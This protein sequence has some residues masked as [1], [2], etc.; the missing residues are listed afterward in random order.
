MQSGSK[1]ITVAMMLRATRVQFLV[2]LIVCCSHVAVCSFDTN[3]TDMQALLEFKKTISDPRQSLM[4]WN[5]STNWCGWD[6][7]RCGVK[8]PN[9]VTSLN[10]TSKGLV[11]RISPS[12]GNM[13]FLN[14][15]VLVANSFTG[16][17]PLALG[18][19]RRLRFV[20]LSNNTLQGQIPSFGN[21]S[22]LEVLWLENN[23][24]VGVIPSDLP[25]GLQSLSF[26]DNSVGGTIPAS[27]ANI[28][29]LRQLDLVGNNIEGNIPTEFTRLLELQILYVG[30][31]KLSGPFPQLVLNLSKLIGFN[32]VLSGLSGDV[33]SNFGNS[34]PNLEYME[35]GGNFFHGLIPSGLSN[36]SKLF[37]IGL[38]Q[39]NFS[40]VVP[41]LGKLSRLSYLNLEKNKLRA[42]SRQDWE[43]MNSLANCTELQ[44]LSIGGN[45]MEGKVPNSLANL[46]SLQ[47]LIMTE[48]QLSGDFPSGVAYLNNLI[49]LSLDGNQFTG[50][51]P[52]WLGT[53]PNLQMIELER[54]IFT[55][56]I[57][58]SFSNMSRLE[59]MY[60]DSNQF[61]GHIPPIL[62][63]MQMLEVLNI[64]DN[65]LQGSI[66]KELFKM[67]RLMQINLSVNNLDGPL[68]S[69][70][71]NAKHLMYLQL[72]SNKLSGEIPS[73][74]ENCDS[75][76]DIELDRN[77]FNGSI[78]TSL[79]NI[80]GLLNINLSHNELTGPIPLSLSS[81]QLL[82][83]LDL[84]FNHLEGEVPT[85]GIFSNV[86]AMRIDGNPGLCGGE[87]ELHLHAC[88]AMT[89][90]SRKHKHSTFEKLMIPLATI[91]PLA[92][93]VYVVLVWKRKQ[94]KKSMSLNLFGSNYPKVSYHDL[95]R[96]TEGFSSSNL[97]GQGRYSYVYRGI[98]FQ[99]RTVVAVKVFNLGT[100][101]TQKSFIAECNALKNIRHRNL[102]PILTACSSIDLNGN[103]FKALVYKIM[104]Q[105]DLHLLLYSTRDDG[106]TSA[107][108]R[109]TLAQRLCIVVNVA[110]AMEY[111]HHNNQGTIVHCD[112][113][114]SNILL[115]DNMV[116]H[117]GDFGL[118]RFIDSAASS[119]K[120]STSSIAIK[121]TVGYVP[122]EYAAGA[123]VSSS[124]D[125]Y[126]F[127]IILLETF[128]RRRPTDDMFRDGLDIATY[129]AMNFPDRIIQIV[130]PELLEERYDS[131]PQTSEPMKEKIMECLLSV[132]N[133]GLRCANP[134]PNERMDMREVAAMLH[135][136]K[137][138]FVS[139]LQETEVQDVKLFS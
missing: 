79:G 42:K 111:L 3:Y 96:A 49:M 80:S 32:V 34:L 107:S 16:E 69:D 92:I 103:D 128:L 15:L 131:L 35:L 21:C 71:G 63:N 115:D 124:G 41:T 72:S 93:I 17:I 60:L 50:A 62:G 51:V 78:P 65:N 76:E 136:I 30:I 95:S 114:P 27:I 28:S 7:V 108:N 23:N 100:N 22:N 85:K 44:Q 52:E 118:A 24:L 99:D 25:H 82:Q 9:R 117:V 87:L 98:L 137:E 37:H 48:N 91:L 97:I 18:H 89:L 40:G 130:D 106:D 112:L 132:L 90:N 54:N 14:V 102:V 11:G 66:P 39:N 77:V 59:R 29:T 26:F 138:S 45:H 123:D 20:N 133:V 129:V 68:H 70:I 125:V 19:L 113:K 8:H 58:S 43:F 81:L 36:A 105:G 126:S 33:P 1:S 104:Q 46:S 10:L 122:P 75:L 2:V 121:G 134:S 53:L 116:A 135:R 55:G 56:A 120:V 5:D 38:S 13:T 73:T 4:S 67:P 47:Y 94:K 6:G 74:L 86:T 31:N 109:I 84:S 110:D 119:C 57:P 12:I 101:G 88:S 64:P 61:S 127:G 83:H 139:Q